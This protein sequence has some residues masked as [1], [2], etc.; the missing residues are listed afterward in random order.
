MQF[1]RCRSIRRVL[2]RE[3]IPPWQLYCSLHTASQ[4]FKLRP[5][6]VDCLDACTDALEE[7][8]T[9]I[10]VS[11]PTGSGKTTVFLNLIPR[12]QPPRDN[13]NRVMII[14]SS[15]EIVHQVAHQARALFPHMTTEIEQG[16]SN[17]ASGEADMCAPSQIC[18]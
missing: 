16:S 13:A 3:I 1:L 15:Q 10:G 2:R 4:Q 12:I 14:G 18:P 8:L 7:G 9:R 17:R 11:L 5:Y 6:Q